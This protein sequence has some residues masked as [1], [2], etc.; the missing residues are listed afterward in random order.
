MVAS[1]LATSVE[2]SLQ[3]SGLTGAVMEVADLGATKA[4]YEVL[5]RDVP[6]RW[7]TSD[8]RQRAVAFHTAGQRIEFVQHRSPR[9]LAETGRHLALRIAAD[10]VQG[11]L[12]ELAAKGARLNWWREDHPSEHATVAYLSDP[13]GNLL[14]LV[15]STEAGLLLEHATME[16][17]DPLSETL[18]PEEAFFARAL[19]GTV[20]YWHGLRVE[21]VREARAQS[22]GHEDCAPWTRRLRHVYPGHLDENYQPDRQAHASPSLQLFVRFANTRLG[23]VLTNNPNLQEPPEGLVKGMP[24]LILQTGLATSDAADLLSGMGYSFQREEQSIFIRRPSGNF[25]E[26]ECGSAAT[27]SGSP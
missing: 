21:D 18:E 15:P 10:R 24:R 3:V 1:S 4:F 5:F 11:I 9:T 27:S 2:S 6:G 12:D 20:D 13:S 14:Q 22:P 8:G 23:F 16:I 17:E 25:F 19:G 26:I 7:S